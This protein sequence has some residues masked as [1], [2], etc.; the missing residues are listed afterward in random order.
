MV[1]T[2]PHITNGNISSP[3]ASYQTGGARGMTGGVNVPPGSRFAIEEGEVAVD[4]Q[5]VVTSKSC[6]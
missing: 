5:H 2:S 6:K 3:G 4:A 1:A